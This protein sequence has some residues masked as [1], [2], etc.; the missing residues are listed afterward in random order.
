[1]EC[2]TVASVVEKAQYEDSTI[3][4]SMITLPLRLSITLPGVSAQDSQVSESRRSVSLKRAPF[5][6]DRCQGKKFL[7]LLVSCCAS[8]IHAM[9]QLTISIQWIS[10]GDL[11]PLLSHHI[12]IALFTLVLTGQVM[13]RFVSASKKM[14]FATIQLI[15]TLIMTCL[16][17]LFTLIGTIEQLIPDTYAGPLA[18]PQQKITFRK[19]ASSKTPWITIAEAPLGAFSRDLGIFLCVCGLLSL[20]CP[21]QNVITLGFVLRSKEMK[22]PSYRASTTRTDSSTDSDNVIMTG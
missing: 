9:A 11:N 19:D 7:I 4:E 17:T 16:L 15:T 6:F 8:V 22:R 12:I 2:P 21:I 5:Y 14:Q 20:V 13:F 10:E 1:M 18:Q 3:D